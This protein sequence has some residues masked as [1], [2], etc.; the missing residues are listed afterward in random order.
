MKKITLNIVERLLLPTTL[1][2]S[3][4]IEMMI[5][6]G[7]VDRVRFSVKEIE[8]YK[9]KDGPGGTI[10]MSPDAIDQKFDFDFEESEFNVISK[11]LKL[12]IES[13]IKQKKI[14]LIHLYLGEKF[15]VK[16]APEKK[17]KQ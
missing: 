8:E 15:G 14:T 12:T 17:V 5:V 16:P 9:L 7:I 6:K 13:L 11:G 1:P 4:G 10:D 2:Q 3:G